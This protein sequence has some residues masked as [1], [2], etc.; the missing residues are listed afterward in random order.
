MTI[1]FRRLKVFSPS[2]TIEMSPLCT[3]YFNLIGRLLLKL[4]EHIHVSKG[5]LIRV[6]PPVGLWINILKPRVWQCGCRHLVF[7]LE[8]EVN[9]VGRDCGGGEDMHCYTS[10]LIGSD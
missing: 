3:G 10:N 5:I 8:P 2:T 1:V 7:V 6:S 4:A 9:I